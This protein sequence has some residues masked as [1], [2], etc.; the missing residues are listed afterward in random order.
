MSYY[1]C[2]MID[3]LEVVTMEFLSLTAFSI[4]DFIPY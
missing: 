2:F 1:I 4:F 3:V